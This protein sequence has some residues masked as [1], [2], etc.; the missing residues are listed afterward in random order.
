M[1]YC[2]KCGK[3]IDDGKKLCDE[4][5]AEL[6]KPNEEQSA[7]EQSKPEP[8]DADNT[9]KKPGGLKTLISIITGNKKRLLIITGAVRL[10]ARSWGTTGR[11][12][13]VLSRRPAEDVIRLRVRLLGMIG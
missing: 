8:D 7:A 1:A 12:R 11:M 6:N 5:A 10:R 2:I 9:E 3:E 4:C 13:L